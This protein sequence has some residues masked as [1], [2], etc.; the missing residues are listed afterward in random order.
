ME[1]PRTAG[2]PARAGA[3]EGPLL[4]IEGLRTHF[5]TDEGLVKAV[6]GV[7][8]EI[9]R[10]ETLGVVGES[11]CG[12]SVTAMSILKLNPEPPTVYAGGRILFEGRDLLQLSDREMRDVRGNDI[13]MIFQEPMTSLNPVFTVGN[14]VAETVR[15]HKGLGRREARDYSIDMLRKVGIPA[16][17]QR[18][19]E[20][21]HQL[22]GGM[23][24][25]VMIAMALACGP[26]LLIADEPTTALDVTIQAQIL[27]L[28]REMQAQMGMSILLIT[29]DLGVVA[30]MSDHVA[31]MYA[32][33]IVEYTDTRT[34]YREPRHPY[35]YGLFQS[36]PEM[37][38][39]G[40]ARLREIPGV[41]PNPLRFPNGCKFHP[42]CFKRGAL[43]AEHEPDLVRGAGGHELACHYPVTGADAKAGART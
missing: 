22:S 2:A 17:E 38:A 24:Q 7:T 3:A 34:L 8:Y 4:R 12:K 33:K 21:P 5:A 18:V 27:D 15:L 42:R 29:H 32:G 1:R 10:G 39:R 9:H 36:L 26:K 37:H 13:A 35:T 40:E 30:E 19:D 25:R 11:G 43:C 23:K 41:V 16:P 28:L 14:Q 6:D 31:V 20:Y